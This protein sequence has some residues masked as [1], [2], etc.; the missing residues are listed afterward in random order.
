MLRTLLLLLSLG[1]AASAQAGPVSGSWLG[2]FLGHPSAMTLDERAD[3]RLI[4]MLLADPNAR[5]IGGSVSGKDVTLAIDVADPGVSASGTFVGTLH[6]HKLTGTLT[7]GGAATPVS[8]VRAHEKYTLESWVMGEDEIQSRVLRLLDKKGGFLSGGYVDLEDCE[9]LSCAG[10]ITAWDV[11]GTMHTLTAESGGGCPSSSS[12]VGTWSASDQV[13]SGSYAHLDCGGA[14]AG[15]F[16]AGKGGVTDAHDL[17]RV[18]ELLADLADRVEAESPA[19]IAL[20]SP[21][22][23]N[24][25]KTRADWQAE[26][27]SLYADYDD[28]EV[29]VAGIDEVATMDDGEVNPLVGGP[30]RV[31]WHVVV[32]GTPSGGGAVETVADE[33]FG[34]RENQQLALIGEEQGHFVF[35]GNGYSEPFAID[36]PVASLADSAHVA[37]GLWPFG[38]H[39][40][41]HPEG[42]PGWDVEFAAG[43]QVHAAADGTVASV[44]PND[45]FP[46]QQNVTIEHR[47]GIATR[48]DHLTNLQPGIVVGAPVAGGA[49]LGDPGTFAPGFHAVHFALTYYTDSVCPTPALT[50]AA[51]TLFDAIWADAAYNEE[52]TEPFPCQPES[53]SFPL[54]RVWQRN[55]GGLAPRIDFS[56][57]SGASLGY[58]YV[59]RDAGGAATETGTATIDPTATPASIDLVPDGGG[60]THLGVYRVVSGELLLDWDDLARPGSL[61]GA[62][63]YG[64]S[65]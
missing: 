8:F 17:G 12:L 28:L 5:I 65:P 44:E 36:L 62:S 51:Q 63:T 59:L 49:V 2:D 54:V 27:A 40:G 41:G 55:A 18:L 19:A 24:D 20:F 39:G 38:V 3:G 9:F 16:I 57:A 37:Y 30:P 50:P 14:K 45:S 56:R 31:G 11:A 25:G 58:G 42:H 47:P 60:A 7:L 32:T 22:Y 26:L 4:G 64:T 6:G 13:L 33:V 23:L 21:G 10:D 35:V 61:A 15:S 43:A 29:Q 1:L 52:L 34:L 53:V 46:G 48:Y